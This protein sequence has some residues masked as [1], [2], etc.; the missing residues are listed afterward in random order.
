MARIHCA[1]V[2]ALV[3]LVFAGQFLQRKIE[4]RGD[5]QWSSVVFASHH[6]A[7]SVLALKVAACYEQ[8]GVHV[9]MD[10]HW[11]QPDQLHSGTVVH[12][13]RDP[14]D[15][16]VSGYLYHKTTDEAWTK[17]PG[18]TATLLA[19]GNFAFQAS[20]SYQHFLNRVD[21]ETG[22]R[23]EAYRLHHGDGCDAMCGNWS[24]LSTAY[25]KCSQLGSQC[26]T[27]CLSSISKAFSPTFGE[28]AA[29][30]GKA[31]AR[32]NQESF[33]ACVEQHDLKRHPRASNADHITD[34]RVSAAQL[35]QMKEVV[36][37]YDQKTLGGSLARSNHCGA[38]N[39]LDAIGL[40]MPR[41]SNAT[42]A[43][44][45]EEAED[46]FLQE[47][48]IDENWGSCGEHDCSSGSFK[49][50]ARASQRG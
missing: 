44:S 28:I 6:K 27:V 14:I 34:N 47:D 5:D 49:I 30:L 29:F 21:R 33:S 43:P 32:E 19:G 20:E 11:G 17:S 45:E 35:A 13:V 15:T 22:L 18:Y 36:R 48:M 42:S 2:A 38:K 25:S 26:H 10:N 41:A 8:I 46:F 50:H 24:E 40:A 12:F 23:A 37:A 16:V 4:Q 9:Q 39:V 31:N 1:C 3:Q 7:G